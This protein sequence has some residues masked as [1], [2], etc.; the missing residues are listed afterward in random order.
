MI[1]E[2]G[3]LVSPGDWWFVVV[4]VVYTNGKVSLCCLCDNAN[5]RYSFLPE[6]IKNYLSIKEI[7][8]LGRGW[9]EREIKSRSQ[10]LADRS[11]PYDVITEV[12]TG[13]EDDR[14]SDW[15]IDE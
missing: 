15:E 12:L 11:V 5:N 2:K 13:G 14:F 9:P 4:S 8:R 7:S 6:E 3:M 1:L 10:S